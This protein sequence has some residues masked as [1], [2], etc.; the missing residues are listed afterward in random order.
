MGCAE[1]LE[2]TRAIETGAAPVATEA[3]LLARIAVNPTI[4]GGKSIIRGR[5]PAVERMLGMLAAGGSPQALDNDLREFP[6][7]SGQPRWKSARSGR[8]ADPLRRFRIGRW[9]RA[10]GAS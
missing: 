10:G 4:F 8:T 2:W 5:R 6:V 9:R 3:D 7:V 1:E